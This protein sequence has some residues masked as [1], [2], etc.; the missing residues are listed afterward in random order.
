MTAE[1]KG[2]GVWDFDCLCHDPPK[3]LRIISG[4][5]DAIQVMQKHVDAEHPG[6]TFKLTRTSANSRDW[7]GTHKGRKRN[8]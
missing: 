6:F 2:S 3:T 1:H 8:E 4:P 5:K 7:R